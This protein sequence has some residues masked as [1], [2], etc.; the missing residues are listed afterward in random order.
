MKV[1]TILI[2]LAVLPVVTACSNAPL[3]PSAKPAT[4]FSLKLYPDPRESLTRAGEEITF[5]ITPSLMDK[6][7]TIFYGDGSSQAIAKENIPCSAN[8]K[9]QPIHVSHTYKAGKAYYP[10]VAYND[11]K[12]SKGKFKIIIARSDMKS[13]K[14]IEKLA[15]N[16]FSSQ[17]VGY[18][19]QYCGQVSV[20][21]KGCKGE[22]NNFALG[23][24]TDANFES[25]SSGQKIFTI[26]KDLSLSMLNSEF[27]VL[28][29]N[30]QALTRLAYESVVESEYKN[31]ERIADKKESE[32]NTHLEYSLQ[33][34]PRAIVVEGTNDTE[35]IESASAKSSETSTSADKE[36]KTSTS[37]K[38]TTANEGA[39]AVLVGTNKNQQGNDK[40]KS[41]ITTSKSKR[42]RPIL[43][44]KFKT[45]NYLLVLHEIEKLS[46]INKPGQFYSTTYD[47]GVSKREASMLMNVRLLNR[48]GEILWMKDI[49]G[50]YTDQLAHSQSPDAPE[51][52]IP[53][54][55]LYQQELVVKAKAAG[56]P[57][58]P[59]GST[60]TSSPMMG[61]KNIPIVGPM[62]VRLFGG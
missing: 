41:D 50:S 56:V 38:E 1:K 35:V 34:G 7:F 3:I 9:C 16:N 36:S 33:R 12:D 21:P 55:K 28:E 44:A 23:L 2:S 29:K 52:V 42:V 47:T 58:Q 46:I 19:T 6:P 22:N 51:T 60:P 39:N 40:K 17:L 27:N 4:G 59:Q 26:A 53:V 31:G 43:L 15:I 49:K 37:S 57:E 62:V 20:I 54:P 48:E 10:Y 25:R 45:A 24:L 5:A 32:Y 14:E 13:D 61:F 30:P 18:L 8:G 11:S